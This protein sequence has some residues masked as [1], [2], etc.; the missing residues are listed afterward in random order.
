MALGIKADE[1]QTSS[2]PTAKQS[3]MMIPTA[4]PLE[5]PSNDNNASYVNFVVVHNNTNGNPIAAKKSAIDASEGL[6][7]IINENVNR[8]SY[9]NYLIRGVDENDFKQLIEYLEK[10]KLQFKDQTH[11]LQIFAVAKTYNCPELM[12][13]CLRE[14]DANLNVSNVIEVYRTLWFYGSLTSQKNPFDRKAKGKRIYT[15]EE[16]LA[17][18]VFNVLQFINM[19]A[20]NVLQSDEIGELT[21]KELENIVRQ[22]DLLLRSEIV[23][24]N[25]LIK[26]SR[27]ECRR[28]NIELT[29]EN[30]RRVLGELCY[31]PR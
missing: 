25:A 28:K 15:P 9:G 4:P 8:D 26:W 7:R 5:Q 1:D 13:Y 19:N 20:E 2:S 22:D 10:K 6:R 27:E 31:A 16:Y 14:V 17:F 18:L 24:I 30:E 3:Q 21:F 11:R 29:H 23:L 12:I